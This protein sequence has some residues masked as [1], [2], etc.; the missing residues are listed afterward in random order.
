MV[1]S[2][3]LVV[4]LAVVA[5][6]CNSSKSRSGAGTPGAPAP[7]G[8]AV[9][10]SDLVA[11]VGSRLFVQNPS[12]GL[13]VL[14][15]A[16]PDRPVIAQVT[17]LTGAGGELYVRGPDAFVVFQEGST[18]GRGELVVV[19]DAATAP[20]V[21]ARR[22][23]PGRLLRSRLVGDVL[24][25][26]STAADT[27]WVTA[28]SIGVP[29]IPGLAAEVVVADRTVEVLV[30]DAT[31]WL[32]QEHVPGA[33][34]PTGTR[35]R[36]VSHGP[37]GG[38]NVRGSL[39]LEGAPQGRHH[40]D[41]RGT[42]L[43]IVTSS[44]RAAGSNVHVVD[45]A[46]LDRLAVLGSLRG[47]G[48]GE[49]LRGA[50]FDGDR[51][52]V[53]TYQP[54]VVYRT[55]TSTPGAIVGAG[56]L[57]LIL[58]ID[59]L[60]VVSLADPR[61]PRLDGVLEVP[62]WSDWVF[63]RGDRLV[64]VGRGDQGDRVAV[65]LFDIA[66]PTRP[67]ELRRLEVGDPQATSDAATDVRAVRIVE[68][69]VLGAE[70]M[71][72]LPLT[73]PRWTN[74]VYTPDHRVQLVDIQR[75]DLVRRGDSRHVGLVRR[76]LPFADR[77]LVVTD[78]TVSSLDVTNR[79]AP[80]EAGAVTVGDLNAPETFTPAVIPAP[81][82]VSLPRASGCALS[83]PTPTPPPGLALL[84]LVGLLVARVRAR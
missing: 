62:G 38:L 74:G 79:D 13:V 19:L 46:D 24:L 54:G 61:Q 72:V 22:T 12:R 23:L 26:V 35:L 29:S 47:I 44:G 73:N 60:W 59:P 82:V 39:L 48:Q 70:P 45:A 11:L 63:P 66:D 34:A 52:F 6:G 51:L 55:R 27:T 78:K 77:L 83:S 40:L 1:R 37:G 49:E 53:V 64:C 5:A 10:E 33:G 17:S 20:R 84:V 4:V 2:S 50:R 25:C 57:F 81:T 15:C 30:T 36:A 7:A 9:E 8:A 68:A 21:A 14:D 65:A 16:L 41:Q 42:Q 28:I 32:A 75:H 67:A 31:V 56:G 69:N 76:T 71:V 80:R 43:R 3:V 18:A 58:A